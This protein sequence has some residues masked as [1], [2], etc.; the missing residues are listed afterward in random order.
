MSQAELSQAELSPISS[1]AA[2]RHRCSD[3]QL[4]PVKIE[5]ALSEFLQKCPAKSSREQAV[6]L[7]FS[8]RPARREQIH[9]ICTLSVLDQTPIENLNRVWSG[10]GGRAD[11]WFF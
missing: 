8:K 3:R 7:G 5:T 6:P 1:L 4:P 11:L 9:D 10:T 2:F